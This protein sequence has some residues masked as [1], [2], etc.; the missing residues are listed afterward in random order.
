MP[1]AGGKYWQKWFLKSSDN[2]F[3][4]CAI[5]KCFSSSESM[6]VSLLTWKKILTGTKTFSNTLH[7]EE[8]LC[9]CGVTHW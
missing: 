9:G 7:Q 2:F 3:E 4:S 5:R 1:T 8:M 6:K